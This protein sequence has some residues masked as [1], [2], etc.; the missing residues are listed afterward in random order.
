MCF[1]TRASDSNADSGSPTL[2]SSSWANAAASTSSTATDRARWGGETMNEEAEE[3]PPES[4]DPSGKTGCTGD[5]AEGGWLMLAKALDPSGSAGGGLATAAGGTGD[6]V[7]DKAATCGCDGSV[8]FGAAA[9]G[10]SAAAAGWTT[11]AVL[12]PDARAGSEKLMSFSNMDGSTGAAVSAPSAGCAT[13]SLPEGSGGYTIEGVVGC[14][15][16]RY[17]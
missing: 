12:G 5:D 2:A 4:T 11:D 13:E 14:G 8:D 3:W 10:G 15:G 7:A 6:K 1:A 16:T 9:V 17:R